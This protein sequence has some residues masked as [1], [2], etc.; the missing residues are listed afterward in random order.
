LPHEP[1]L[2]GS[3]FVSTHE[4]PQ[5]VDGAAHW[6]PVGTLESAFVVPASDVGVTE[7]GVSEVESLPQPDPTTHT[8][9]PI[10]AT[11]VIAHA[12]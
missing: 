3:I 10:V 11:H 9:R 6:V 5:T 8:N 12:R 4:L 2:L 7:V 1:Q